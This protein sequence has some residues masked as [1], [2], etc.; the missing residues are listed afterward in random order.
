MPGW[1]TRLLDGL[2]GGPPARRVAARLGERLGA[3][4]SGSR[5]AFGVTGKL[6]RHPCRLALDGEAD[7]M[8]ATVRLQAGERA[9]SMVW[10]RDAGARGGWASL[11]ERVAVPAAD[12]PWLERLPLSVRLHAIEVVEA[13]R[14][15]LSYEPGSL[16]L[17]VTAAGLDRANAAEQ[18][19]IRLDVLEQVAAALPKLARGR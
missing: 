14:G 2:R 1:L 7:R 13:G 11:S 19:E 10:A 12:A 18:A 4:P 6:G 3:A 16:R 17:E 9:W 8:S 5:S 15:S